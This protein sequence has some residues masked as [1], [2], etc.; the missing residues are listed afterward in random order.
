M[1]KVSPTLIGILRSTLARVEQSIDL[2]SDDPAL[3]ELRRR[4]LR[5]IAELEVVNTRKIA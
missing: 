1:E 4:V 5:L 3:A 2:S